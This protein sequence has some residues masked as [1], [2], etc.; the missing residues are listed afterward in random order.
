MGYTV[1]LAAT[2]CNPM[3]I[4]W[5]CLSRC[6]VSCMLG[7]HIQRQKG[8]ELIHWLSPLI[9]QR[10]TPM[11]I[12]SIGLIDFTSLGTKQASQLSTNSEGGE[13]TAVRISRKVHSSCL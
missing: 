8:E 10:F 9:D 13:G 3:Q 12:N 11:C 5:F 6:H 4:L 7:Q 2:K 1:K